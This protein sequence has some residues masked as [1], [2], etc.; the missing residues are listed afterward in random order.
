[1]G[2][3]FATW[4]AKKNGLRA[5]LINPA[6]KPCLGL[7]Q[8]LGGNANY[9]TGETWIMEPHHIDQF[10]QLEVEELQRPEDLWTLLQTGDEVL[11]YRLAEQKC[12][13]GKLT[14]EQEG[15]HSFQ[16]YERMA[17]T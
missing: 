16:G 4:L 1:M 6:V 8:Y 12:R 2:G 11:D 13:G 10:R 14:V 5:V 7:H 3:Y 9:H 17:L 15:D